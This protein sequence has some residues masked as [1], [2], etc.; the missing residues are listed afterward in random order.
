MSDYLE[1]LWIMIFLASAS[2]CISFGWKWGSSTY[3]GVG[4]MLS[5]KEKKGDTPP[6]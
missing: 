1:P 3:D 2:A 5:G 4:R 6:E